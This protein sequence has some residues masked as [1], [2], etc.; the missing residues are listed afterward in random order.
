MGS[1]VADQYLTGGVVD[2]KVKTFAVADSKML[3]HDNA[4]EDTVFHKLGT[5]LQ[6]IGFRGAVLGAE[7]TSG[8]V[9]AAVEVFRQIVVDEHEKRFGKFL[10]LLEARVD[11]LG[12]LPG[13]GQHRYFRAVKRFNKLQTVGGREGFTEKHLA[14]DAVVEVQFCGSGSRSRCFGCMRDLGVFG[15]QKRN[16]LV[17]VG[18]LFFGALEFGFKLR[19]FAGII[20]GRDGRAQIHVQ[21][22]L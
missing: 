21:I 18:E 19:K 1:A 5:H 4:R 9:V 17:S 2:L 16:L 11:F 6:S 15:T 10:C 8:F 12:R 14:K 22:A 3:D 7:H 13:R 20:S